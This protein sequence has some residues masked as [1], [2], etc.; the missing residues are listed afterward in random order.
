MSL[1]AVAPQCAD[2]AVSLADRFS[3]LSFMR[4]SAS[5]ARATRPLFMYSANRSRATSS[6]T[7]DA[8]CCCRT[9]DHA[10]AVPGTSMPRS[11]SLPSGVVSGASAGRGTGASAASSSVRRELTAVSRFATSTWLDVSPSSRFHGTR[12]AALAAPKMLSE[13]YTIFWNVRSAESLSSAC[14]AVCLAPPPISMRWRYAV[15]P[16]A[17]CTR[18]A[19]SSAS[20]MRS[21]NSRS[22]VASPPSS[23]SPPRDMGTMWLRYP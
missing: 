5:F 8:T 11:H 18:A 19:S 10:A 6:G 21:R 3:R 22:L 16:Y 7:R 9:A 15:F 12:Y 2:V 20:P 17:M 23:G 13:R 14:S 4:F 1:I